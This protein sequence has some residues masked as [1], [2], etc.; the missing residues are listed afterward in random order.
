MTVE[1]VVR[2]AGGDNGGSCCF[3]KGKELLWGTKPWAHF[4]IVT[5]MCLDLGKLGL[6][7]RGKDR[8]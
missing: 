5:V 4:D 8:K 1:L 2:E 3:G 7:K 6:L